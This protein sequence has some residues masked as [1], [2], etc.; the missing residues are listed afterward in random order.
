MPNLVG[1]GTAPVFD[2]CGPHQWHRSPLLG[3]CNLVDMKQ[4][5]HLRPD[6]RPAIRIPDIDL[7]QRNG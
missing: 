4:H 3:W 2:I 6:L 5:L 1:P 7:R